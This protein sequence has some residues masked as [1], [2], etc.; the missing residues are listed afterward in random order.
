M[1]KWVALLFV[2]FLV[3]SF[4][5]T[6]ISPQFSELKG[7]EDQ[8][9]NT[10]LFYR[11][12]S[13]YISDPFYEYNNDIFHFD[14]LSMN[15]TLFLADYNYIDPVIAHFRKVSDYS[16]WNNDVSKFI[17]GGSTGS[18]ETI[19]FIKRFDGPYVYLNYSWG[20]IKELDISG[21]EDSLIFAGAWTD[22]KTFRSFDGGHNWD[23]VFDTLLFLSL[24]P[25]DDN[26]MFFEGWWQSRLYRS[27]D[28][29]NTFHLVDVMSEWGS[30]N[31]FIY[32][33][34]QLHIYRIYNYKFLRVSPDKGEAF[35]WQ[36]KYS[37]DSKIFISID[38]STSGTIYLADKK[39]IFISTDYGNSFTL[40]KTL[41]RKIVGIYKK[42]NSEKLYA[43]TKYKIYEITA[44]T[45]QV[46]KSLPI[47]QEVLNYYPLAVGNKWIN[48]EVTYV[49]DPNPNVYF[50]IL[51]KEVLGDT[52]APNGKQYYK[53][54]DETIWESFVL[55]RV[56]STDGVVYRYYEDPSLPENEYVA[57]DLLAEVGDTLSS[58]R[59]G[60][61]TVM[62]TTMYAETIF[63]KWGMTKPKKV[64]EEYTLHPPIFSITQDIGLDSIYSYFDFGETYI[65]LK[66]CIIDGV[67]YGDTT[68]VGVEDEETPIASEFKLEQN[69]PN[70]FN[71]STVI[72]YQLP[73]SSSVTLTI[74]DVLGNEI[75]TLVNEEK[76][77]GEYEA[78][79]SGHSDEGQNL[80]SGVYFY[81]LRVRSTE[82]SSEQNLIQTKKMILLK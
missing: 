74:Y 34:D 5:Q 57:Y 50:R 9:G 21:N 13:L 3:N 37:S 25:F 7:M 81:Q 26:L 1:K 2:C 10:H 76:S 75:I 23:V 4:S 16:F 18:Q 11:I 82:T 6:N 67:I 19:P 70:P 40:Y 17:F 43:A 71:P 33:P 53:V 47:P 51:V 15:D 73:V 79:F 36:T 66:G 30:S 44:D 14:I 72:S 8:L 77:A 31:S 46:I 68:T 41:D 58:Y 27:T 20:G 63:E 61:N 32:D 52:I 54:N 60:F 29:A 38:E 12:Y 35:S 80:P 22:D 42:P 28:G 49:Q 69:Y 24:N 55:E 45:I 48:D 62:F 39:N 64:F 65:T 59:M 78:E 56:D